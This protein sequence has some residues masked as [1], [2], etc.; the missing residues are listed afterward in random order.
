MTEKS[1]WIAPARLRQL[2][3]GTAPPE[4][5]FWPSAWYPAG[6]WTP[7]IRA[8]FEASEAARRAECAEYAR[9]WLAGE[10]IEGI[11]RDLER[12]KRTA[13]SGEGS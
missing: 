4:T 13:A 5:R 6:G 3:D 12:R 1:V 11:K 8:Q 10:E 2:E 7:A 9:R